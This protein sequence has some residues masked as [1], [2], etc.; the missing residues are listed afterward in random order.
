[1]D[2]QGDMSQDLLLTYDGRSQEQQLREDEES[3]AMYMMMMDA[4]DDVPNKLSSIQKEENNELCNKK[5]RLIELLVMASRGSL[6]R[7]NTQKEISNK[8]EI[9]KYISNKENNDII[10]PSSSCAINI[11]KQ[12]VHKQV[13][14]NNKSVSE[15]SNDSE[16][17]YDNDIT[18]VDGKNINTLSSIKENVQTIELKNS[19][20]GPQVHIINGQIVVDEKSLYIPH[21]DETEPLT[22][23]DDNDNNSTDY[24]K[25][26]GR[27]NNPNKWTANQ[28]RLLYHLLGVYGIDFQFI[29]P[30]FPDKKRS[31]VKARFKKEER[32]RP[33]LIKLALENRLPIDEK[34]FQYAVDR[35]REKHPMESINNNNNSNSTTQII[36]NITIENTVNQII[37]TSDDT[38]N[39]KIKD[40]IE[41]KILIDDT[42]EDDNDDEYNILK[43]FA[44]S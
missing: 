40:N 30:Y 20:T 10:T 34:N 14:H 37:K 28:I 44:S 9:K 27:R 2:K 6:K 31:Q 35:Y 42:I 13:I 36:E 1:M 4:A 12:K 29:S 39:N 24:R 19:N 11:K 8:Q 38:I 32:E 22:I 15:I 41:S 23:V 16:S 3:A 33:L 25:C 26:I 43:N 7:T 17:S 18:T 21:T 5:T